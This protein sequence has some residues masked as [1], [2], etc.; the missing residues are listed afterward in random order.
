[1][2]HDE[3]GAAYSM[4]ETEEN[5]YNILVKTSKERED[6]ED[7]DVDGRFWTCLIASEQGTA[8]SGPIEL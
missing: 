3:I 4:H 6:C 5:A 2:K 1:V 8:T 7:L